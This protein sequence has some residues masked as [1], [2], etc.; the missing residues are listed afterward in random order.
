MARAALD[1]EEELRGRIEDAEAIMA[2]NTQG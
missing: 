1:F 2:T